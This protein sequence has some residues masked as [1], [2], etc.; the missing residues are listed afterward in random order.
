MTIKEY[1]EL[2]KEF[3]EAE[4]QANFVH[5]GDSRLPG[6]SYSFYTDYYEAR[7]NGNVEKYDNGGPNA[8]KYSYLNNKA[9]AMIK[10]GL[11]RFDFPIWSYVYH[12]DELETMKESLNQVGF[13]NVNTYLSSHPALEIYGYSIP[14]AQRLKATEY[15]EL[16]TLDD[17]LSLID[18]PSLSMWKL[19]RDGLIPLT[20]PIMGTVHET[21]VSDEY[22]KGH[23]I[24]PELFA[25]IH[26]SKIEITPA[27][28]D[29]ITLYL[30]REYNSEYDEVMNKDDYEKMTQEL[31][32]VAQ[33]KQN[34]INKR[35]QTA[36]EKIR[37]Y[38]D[39]YKDNQSMMKVLSDD[40]IKITMIS[41]LL[42][43]SRKK[44]SYNK[45]DDFFEELSNLDSFQVTNL[46]NVRLL[47]NAYSN[48]RASQIFSTF[49]PETSKIFGTDAH[50]GE[51][52]FNEIIKPYIETK[53][54]ELTGMTIEQGI[55]KRFQFTAIKGKFSHAHIDS[56]P[57]D[58][59]LTQS[60]FK[61]IIL[62]NNNSVSLAKALPSQTQRQGSGQGL[63]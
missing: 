13:P 23:S 14:T 29:T 55:E 59:R 58:L 5:V 15:P 52:V 26:F 43:L 56:I 19:K 6:H 49:A 31:L 39:K 44:I 17:K 8:N 22:K 4:K 18:S 36:E 2:D 61:D 47:Q 57:E 21:D 42:E 41:C 12:R 11:L 46:R 50:Y 38:K 7:Y 62:D 30:K 25:P 60:P 53:Y 51:I 9:I 10:L 54:T 16:A 45:M 1:M 33:G 24:S 3:R 32:S 63:G 28:H 34:A 27:N 37:Y 40:S 48:D 35:E 20:L